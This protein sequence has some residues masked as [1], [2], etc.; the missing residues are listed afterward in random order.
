MEQESPSVEPLGMSRIEELRNSSHVLNSLAKCDTY[1][2]ASN[3][4]RSHAAIKGFNM[5]FEKLTKT[6]DLIRLLLQSEFQFEGV[7]NAYTPGCSHSDLI[8]AE[9]YGSVFV[10]P[11]YSDMVKWMKKC[12]EQRNKGHTVVAI[13]PS[14]TNTGWFHEHVLASADNELRFIRGRI[15][16]PGFKS[17]SPYPDAICIFRPPSVTGSAS[18]S[19]LSS[20]TSSV[21]D[22]SA[23][24]HLFSNPRSVAIMSCATSFTSVE[25]SFSV[26]QVSPSSADSQRSDTFSGDELSGGESTGT[27]RSKRNKRK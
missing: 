10:I 26:A 18:S 25:T 22:G 15:T 19:S 14:R 5:V 27:R 23:P 21:S 8:A 13:M 7:V 11:H 16:M 2:G 6:P 20:L 17:Q 3:G 12:T 24:G 9:W 1:G 4:S